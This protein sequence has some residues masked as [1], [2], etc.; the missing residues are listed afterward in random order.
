M[1]RP[2]VLLL[3]ALL[4]QSS[5]QNSQL[6]LLGSWVS[7]V[8]PGAGE[9]PAISPTFSI[10]ARDAKVVVVFPNT[11]LPVDAT[12]F[13]VPPTGTL[14]MLEPP[15]TQAGRRIII[16]RLLTVNELKFELFVEYSGERAKQNFYYSETFKR[17][18]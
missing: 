3:T 6:P 5:A 13:R 4:S 1:M 8:K 16:L 10:E 12:M 9:A 14:L 11:P 2:I 15:I 17:A 7:T 18:Q